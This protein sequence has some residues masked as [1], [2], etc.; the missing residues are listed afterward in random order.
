M[1]DEARQMLIINIHDSF[2]SEMNNNKSLILDI[3]SYFIQCLC[4][5]YF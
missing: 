4:A 1:A 3:M 2:N 5:R